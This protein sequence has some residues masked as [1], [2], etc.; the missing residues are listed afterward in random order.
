MKSSTPWG[1]LP[2]LEVNAKVIGQSRAVHRY[3]A[4]LFDLAGKSLVDQAIADSVVDATCDMF[5]AFGPI[6]FAPDDK[7]MR[8][9][10][11]YEKKT[12]IP[13]LA[14]LERTLKEN[15]S[16][17]SFFVGNDI[18]WADINFMV[19][20]EMIMSVLRNGLDSAPRLKAL[21]NRIRQHPKIRQYMAKQPVKRFAAV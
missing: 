2:I 16:G 1:T 11:E 13:A 4:K 7:K 9:A 18:T 10:K 3:V 17:N 14:N 6:F 21:Y 12:L 20:I 19:G 15:N 5:D 8:M